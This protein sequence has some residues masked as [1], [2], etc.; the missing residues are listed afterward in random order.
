MLH[1]KLYTLDSAKSL[2]YK[3]IQYCQIKSDNFIKNAN[4]YWVYD[5]FYKRNTIYTAK[6]SVKYLHCGAGIENDRF[7]FE[8]LIGKFNHFV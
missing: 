4:D 5:R 3:Q 1:S 6:M 2:N 8:D 7:L